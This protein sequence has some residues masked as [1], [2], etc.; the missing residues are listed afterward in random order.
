MSF[1]VILYITSIPIT[2]LTKHIMICFW[3][4]KSQTTN[5]IKHTFYINQPRQK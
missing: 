1:L 3:T 4:K 5:L 2:I